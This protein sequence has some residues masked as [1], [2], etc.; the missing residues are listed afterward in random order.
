[1]SQDPQTVNYT[2]SLGTAS[3][4]DISGALT[5]TVSF[6]AGVTTQ[7][8]TVGTVPDT[9]DENNETVTV[10]LSGASG[11]ETPVIGTAAA[12]GTIIDNDTVTMSIADT[13]VTE[14]GDLVF[15]VSR[16]TTSQDPQTVNYT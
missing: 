13:S 7:T 9:I 3:A 5:G 16:S 1:T 14:G 4:S 8:I 10:T 6:A 2:V 12:T 15:T 11:T